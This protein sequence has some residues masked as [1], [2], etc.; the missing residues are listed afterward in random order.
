MTS[1]ES[2]QAML[3]RQLIA[4]LVHS[5]ESA[6]GWQQAERYLSALRDLV[7]HADPTLDARQIDAWTEARLRRRD[8]WVWDGLRD[9]AAQSTHARLSG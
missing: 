4:Q 2:L 3:E 7:A 9:G 1:V 5:L 6:T 8:L